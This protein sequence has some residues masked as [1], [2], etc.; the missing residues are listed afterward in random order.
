MNAKL[1]LDGLVEQFA[2][3]ADVTPFIGKTIEI[4]Y[5]RRNGVIEM[6]IEGQLK[7]QAAIN[8]RIP[9]GR[10]GEGAEI[11]AAVAFL[12]SREAAYMTGETLHV[13]GGMAM[14]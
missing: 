12:A 8:G 5:Q 14:L 1:M 7:Q 10:M 2:V 6:Y 11:G 3:G 9:M 13:N 4:V